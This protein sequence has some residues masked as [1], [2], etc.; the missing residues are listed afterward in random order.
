MMWFLAVYGTAGAILGF[1][2]GGSKKL[3]IVIVLAIVAMAVFQGL[4]V[5]TWG[6]LEWAIF[7]VCFVMFGRLGRATAA[8]IRQRLRKPNAPN[9]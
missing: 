3:L 7:F 2:S 8:S 5:L 9:N 6:F 1:L 4:R